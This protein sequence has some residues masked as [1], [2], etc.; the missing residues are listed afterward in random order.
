VSCSQILRL[1]DTLNPESPGN[2]FA[3]NLVSTNVLMRIESSEIV[4]TD[5]WRNSS[6]YLASEL[7]QSL[8]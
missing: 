7:I 2:P 1:R 6:A 4:F 3:S 5:S 8:G